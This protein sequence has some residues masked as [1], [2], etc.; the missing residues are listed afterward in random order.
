MNISRC[1]VSG[2]KCP[3]FFW[4]ISFFGAFQYLTRCNLKTIS[5]KVY[6]SFIQFISVPNYIISYPNYSQ[7]EVTPTLSNYCIILLYTW[8]S[9][10]F[11]SRADPTL[12][13]SDPWNCTTSGI[14]LLRLV[15]LLV[16]TWNSH[17]ILIEKAAAKNGHN[18][19]YYI[20]CKMDM[21]EI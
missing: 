4:G 9:F 10:E 11:S 14:K 6:I 7:I 2:K 15:K 1:M 21:F 3:P 16:T 5:I 19:K 8:I 13:P 20:I 18:W 17:Q 12:A